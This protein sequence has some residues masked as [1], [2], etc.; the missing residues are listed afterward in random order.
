MST[1]R[2]EVSFACTRN[3]CK[4]VGNYGQREIGIRS[5][6]ACLPNAETRKGREKDFRVGGVAVRFTQWEPLV[7]LQA[8]E[9]GEE[10]QETP[11]TGAR[12]LERV[13]GRWER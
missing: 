4:G 13:T 12:Q 8:W 1:P 2:L 3:F 7:F 11:K 6:F 5:E 9:A 10:F